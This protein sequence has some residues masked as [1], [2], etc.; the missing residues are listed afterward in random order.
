M[1]YNNVNTFMIRI[2][3]DYPIVREEIKLKT[4]AFNEDTSKIIEDIK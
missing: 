4:I 3:K 1:V 2:N